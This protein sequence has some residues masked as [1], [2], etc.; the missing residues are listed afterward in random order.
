MRRNVGTV[1]RIVRILS[2]II[3]IAIGVYCKSWLGIIGVIPLATGLIGSCGLY[4]LFG[5]STCRL[6]QPEK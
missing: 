5:I 2:G 6:K 3:I 4:S 1:D